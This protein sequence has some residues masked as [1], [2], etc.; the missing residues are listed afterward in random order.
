[1]TQKMPKHD[2]E[3]YQRLTR[4]EEGQKQLHQAVNDK[5]DLLLAKLDPVLKIQD[6]VQEHDRQI[7]FWR[8]ANALLGVLWIGALAAFGKLKQLW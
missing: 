3:L 1:M 4:I 6:V 5:H 7:S 8:G 2:I